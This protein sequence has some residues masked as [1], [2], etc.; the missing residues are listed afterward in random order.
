MSERKRQGGYAIAAISLLGLAAMSATAVMITDGGVNEAD[1]VEEQLVRLRAEWA[2]VGHMTYAISRARQ[3]GLCDPACDK[4]DND[5]QDRLQIFFTEPFNAKNSGLTENSPNRRRW[6]YNE[7]SSSYAID[8][9]FKLSDLDSETEN[10]RFH[11]LYDFPNS[12]RFEHITRILARM[13]EFQSSI[14]FGLAS[15]GDPCP[16][17]LG[18]NDTGGIARIADFSVIQ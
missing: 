9:D 7:I 13:G 15:A 16:V 3:D 1:R 11:V 4:N 6:Q 5:R 14:C 8:T 18:V 17:S 12:N 10:G 2:V